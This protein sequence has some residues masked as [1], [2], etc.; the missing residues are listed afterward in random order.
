M[1]KINNNKTGEIIFNLTNI[2]KKISGLSRVSIYILECLLK[3]YTAFESYVIEIYLNKS[4][5][6]YLIKNNLKLNNSNLKIKF[7]PSIFSPDFRLGNKLRFIWTNLL[8][9]KKNNALIFNPSQIEGVLLKKN[10]KTIII[11]HDLIPLFKKEGWSYY[12][13]KYILPLILEKTELIITVS[14]FTKELLST[15]YKI[16]KHNIFVI[17]PPIDK[18]FQVKTEIKKE[19]IIL[20][21]GR[22]EEYKNIKKLINAFEIILK[23]MPN[24][25]LFLVGSGKIEIPNHLNNFVKVLQNINDEDL[26]TLYNKA[27]VFVLPSLYEGFGLPPLEAMACGCPVVVSNTSSLPEICGDAAIYVDPYDEMSIAE[28]IYKILVNENLASSLVRKGLEHVKKFSFDIFCNNLLK[29]I[30]KYK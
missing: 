29:I 15:I 5:E 25:K 9:L 19:P 6:N 2:G 24:Y 26:I 18:K 12:Y 1:K 20:F 23:K 4:V 10:N 27:S 13:Y 7:I 3:N 22:F 30:T 8:S 11:I 28:G 14:N 17:Y 21:V 16:N